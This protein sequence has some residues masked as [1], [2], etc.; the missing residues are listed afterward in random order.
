MSLYSRSHFGG[1]FVSNYSGSKP[2]TFKEMHPTGFTEHLPPQ[3]KRSGLR[4]TI[5]KNEGELEADQERAFC[6]GPQVDNRT[7]EDEGAV[8]PFP[9]LITRNF[10]DGIHHDVALTILT[11]AISHRTFCFRNFGTG[12]LGHIHQQSILL[13]PWHRR[14]VTLQSSLTDN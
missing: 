13:R 14:S 12:E 1:M 10:L 7:K 3:L 4:G 5:I 9:L 8:D 2:S 6:D 11:A